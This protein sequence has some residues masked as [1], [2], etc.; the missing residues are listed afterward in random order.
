MH[1]PVSSG[2]IQYNRLPSQIDLARNNFLPGASLEI[3]R[4]AKRHKLQLQLTLLVSS[5]KLWCKHLL[6]S[7]RIH[8]WNKMVRRDRTV[9]LGFSDRRLSG[10]DS[11]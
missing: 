4:I 3:D 7:F 6:R 1:D 8:S 9:G 5:G 2:H 10:V 11:D